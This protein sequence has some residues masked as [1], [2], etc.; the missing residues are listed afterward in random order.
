MKKLKEFIQAFINVSCP[1]H[2]A[3]QDIYLE[4]GCTKLE[5]EIAK[6]AIKFLIKILNMEKDRFPWIM[7]CRL[8][9][10]STINP[11]KLN[12]ISQLH[13]LLARAEHEYLIDCVD[14]AT[15]ETALPA[16]DGVLKRISFTE[17]SSRAAQSCFCP[18]Y[19]DIKDLSSPYYESYLNTALPLSYIRTFA[20]CRLAGQLSLTMNVNKIFYKIN[21]SEKCFACNLNAKEDVTHIL[22]ECPMYENLRAKYLNSEGLLEILSGGC[23]D[24]IAKFF[25]YCSEMLKKRAFILSESDV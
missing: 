9:Q 24:R 14:P 16:I 8:K 19:K 12:W 4:T 11:S 22:V 2:A 1:S 25:Y 7:Y 20:A 17:D 10:Q 15:F 23:K 18:L 6:R 21:L 5:A 13:T 3:L